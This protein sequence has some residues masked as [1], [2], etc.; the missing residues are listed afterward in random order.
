MSIASQLPTSPAD[1]KDVQ[2]AQL[3]QILLE[4]DTSVLTSLIRAL[5]Y[6][7]QLAGQPGSDGLVARQTL[8]KFKDGLAR[9]SAIASGIDIPTAA[10]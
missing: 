5:V 2:I 3:Q 10:P 4:K 9:A 7:G 6:Y 1:P 8:R